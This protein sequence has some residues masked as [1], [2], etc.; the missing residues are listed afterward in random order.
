MSRAKAVALL[1][2]L[3]ALQTDESPAISRILADCPELADNDWINRYGPAS[4][5][6]EI[7]DLYTTP[8][9][10]WL[11]KVLVIAE[12]ELRWSGGSVAAP[13]WLF[14]AYQQRSDATAD[15]LAEW[16]LRNKGNDYL[17]FGSM[18]AA[19]SLD[20]WHSERIESADR[21]AAHIARQHA[22]DHA[23][24][25]RLTAKRDNA[26]HRQQA[27]QIRKQDVEQIIKRLEAL[28][29]EARLHLIA[30]D[31]TI[32]LGALSK[33]LIDSLIDAV[34]QAT[35]D[36]RNRL[37]RRIDRRQSGIWKVLRKRLEEIGD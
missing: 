8:V 13:V 15:L 30:T 33:A 37:L 17:P 32:P 19:R 14:R 34:Q 24:A 7:A 28:S 3:A 20:E 6:S 26:T 22:E 23:K 29:P 27:A 4:G 16:M 18:S 36:E 21:R 12:R 11:I 10:A 5:W 1:N 31:E 35:S 9:L 2:R 25:A